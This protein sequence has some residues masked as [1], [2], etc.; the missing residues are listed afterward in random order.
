MGE[1]IYRPLIED[2]V[3]SYSRLKC[4]E[5]CPYRWYMKYICNLPDNPR[6]YSSFG[7]FVH[8]LLESYYKGKIKKEDLPREFL[9]GFSENVKGERPSEK[10]VSNYI[11]Q[12]LLYFRTFEPVDMNV[13]AVEKK[14]DYKI[15]GIP[16]IGFAD[17]VCEKNG[18]L[19]IVDH[20]SKD[21]KPRSNRKKETQNDRDL[22]E[23][24]RQLYI[25]AEAV[26]QTY[27]E[28]PTGLCINCF[29]TG[30]FIEEPFQY[31]EFCK[32]IDWAK[33]TVEEIMDVD[34]FHPWIEY[35]PCKYICGLNE[36]CC[37]WERS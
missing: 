20:K 31:E 17:L 15:D 33:R 23:T 10:I 5:D 13:I 24:L 18:D 32:T 25:Y 26:K 36:E 8:K 28:Y 27:G 30:V 12:G 19:Y 14:F 9:L 21:L 2:M 34:S 22:D 29:R 7:S 4:F 11:D 1:M 35:F 3:W 6:F 37:Y 16:F